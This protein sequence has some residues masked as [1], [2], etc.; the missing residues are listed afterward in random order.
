MIL[1]RAGLRHHLRN[2]WQAA[3]AILGVAL[4]VA[5]VVAVELANASAERAFTRSAEA[6][7]GDATHRV[8]A[9]SAGLDEGLYAQL[10]RSG[11]RPATPVVEGYV[12]G[13]QGRP[14]RV[15]GVDPWAEAGV[16]DTVA[17]AAFRVDAADWLGSEAAA[18]LFEKDAQRLGIGA[19]DRLDVEVGGR[20]RSLVVAAV[21]EPADA[22]TAEG[23]RD[24]V[25]VDIATAQELLGRVGRLDRIDLVVPDGAPGER[26]LAR[27]AEHLPPEA[28]VQD[29]QDGAA[30]LDEMTAAFRLNLTAF[31]LL[32]LLV[33][34]LLIYNAISFS[35]V[36]RRPLLGRLR[37]LG[38]GRGQLFRGVVAEGVLLGALGTV[39]GL[40]LGYALAEILLELVTRTITDLYFVLSVRDVTLAP[41]AVAMA[42]ILGVV[43]AGGAAAAPAWEA[44]SVAP[45]SALE[46]ASLE[47]R[48]RRWVRW[49][50]LA[51][52]G[53]AALGG[54]LLWGY[55]GGLVV[56]FAGVFA[57]LAGAALVVPWAVYTLALVAAY[58]AGAVF[59]APG[60]MAARG[61]AA[62][63]S[64]S[65]V[66]GTA[67]VIAVTAV[68]GVTVMIDS[69]RGSLAT[70][71]ETTLSADVYVS[72]PSQA[73]DRPPALVPDLAERLGAV[74]GV[75]YVATARYLRVP[76]AYGEVRLRAFDHGPIG[77]R[78]MRYKDRTADAWERFEA[79]EAAFVTE[80]FAA[81]HKLATGDRIALRTPQG[82]HELP[83][84]AVVY[85][86]TTSEG[87]VFVGRAFYDDHWGDEAIN[88]LAVHAAT[89]VDREGLID[90]LRQAAGAE[91]A[92]LR[93]RSDAEIRQLSLEVFDRTFAITRVLQLL[94]TVV[95]A[96]G[97]FGALFALS[98]ERTG[99]VAVLR[100]LGLTPRQVGVLELARTGLLGGFAGLLAIPP[101]LALAGA[102]TGVINQRAFGWSLQLSV[103]PAVLVQGVVLASGAALLA[104][105]Y[106]AY[107][108]ARIPPGEAMRDEG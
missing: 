89:G 51:G 2:P 16:R 23:L 66:A 70:W 74:D 18:V 32:A 1:A 65:G 41:S 9:G 38:V 98:L 90:A 88:S 20:G 6:L 85:D 103:D 29:A 25:V 59:G 86:Y 53:L 50:A 94:A 97:V 48:A 67:L 36:Q 102:L 73:G 87:A 35:V 44:A 78:G 12:D 105:L 77:D 92:A 30:A 96:A 49:L 107:R 56:G 40:P 58:P 99:E 31:S 83:V 28:E 33:G 68:I 104:G 80:P 22:L 60:R 4:G 57:L 3:L 14:L 19:G 82:V 17:G 95:A 55:G 42:A 69:F 5:V 72:A 26:M 34:A 7:A 54:L 62:G 81:H 71:L 39:L 91:A 75:E 106:P 64:R 93:F 100:A 79:G 8:T 47:G 63:L 101:G 46:R 21:A 10:R 61:V 37:A 43:A 45:R 52:C 24:T 27:V 108:A 13:P 15:L 76:S 11:V 84:A